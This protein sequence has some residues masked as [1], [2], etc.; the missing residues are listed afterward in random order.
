MNTAASIV[1]TISL[2]LAAIGCERTA[3]PQVPET[4]GEQSAL[5]GFPDSDGALVVYPN[6]HSSPSFVDVLANKERYDGKRIRIFGFLH[7]AFEGTAIFYSKDHADRLISSEAIWASFD[8]SAMPNEDIGPKEFHRQWV[9]IEGTF[10]M[11]SRGHLSAYSGELE[12]ID[13]IELADKYYND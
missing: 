3:A 4:H 10:N 13:R 12:S 7:V 5:P 1:A 2:V 11:D 8:T 6:A 9:L